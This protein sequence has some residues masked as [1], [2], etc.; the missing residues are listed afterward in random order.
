M[1]SMNEYLQAALE[2]L[3]KEFE[4]GKKLNRY[5]KV[6]A[7]PVKKQLVAFCEQEPE[8]AQV[9]ALGGSFKECMEAVTKG[10][11][12]S[13]SDVDAYERAVRFYFP[14]SR[15]RFQLTVD[16]VGDA[17]G[18]IAEPGEAHVEDKPRAGIV[19]NLADFLWR[20]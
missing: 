5:S 14:G 11:R 7:G 13:I 10:V 17:A 15:I 16:L 19:L 6:M 4:D 2:R 20:G 8:F 3:E 9:V 12:S 18:D 1:S